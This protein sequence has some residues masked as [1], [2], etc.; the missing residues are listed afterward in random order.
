MNKISRTEG[1][2]QKETHKLGQEEKH[3]RVGGT[4]K[5][6]C[7]KEKCTLGEGD[8]QMG[9]RKMHIWGKEKHTWWEREMHIG[10]RRNVE[11]S[12]N[13]ETHKAVTE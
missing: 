6:T 12:G 7:G 3:I 5:H 13:R 2:G 9:E 8:T 1:E 4:E 10:G 11:G